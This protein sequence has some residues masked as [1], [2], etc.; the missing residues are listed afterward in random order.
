M[1]ESNRSRRKG[2]PPPPILDGPKALLSR[3]L[4]FLNDI[5]FPPHDS[6][7]AAKDICRKLHPASASWDPSLLSYVMGLTRLMEVWH[8]DGDFTTS[9]GDPRRLPLSGP[10]SFAELVARVLPDRSAR[11]VLHT[12]IRNRAVRRHGREVEGLGRNIRFREPKLV[13][14]HAFLVM[15]STVGVF[16]HN[17]HSPRPVPEFAATNA[18]IP[19]R[20]LPALYREMRPIAR[21]HA[22]TVDNLLG[23]YRPDTGS[24]EPITEA[25]YI[26]IVTDAHTTSPK[27]SASKSTPRNRAGRTPKKLRGGV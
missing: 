16:C 18:R 25:M 6:L 20:K 2:T 13:R 15:N 14:A 9:H 26:I 24:S 10:K 12:L 22:I 21:A 11:T 19:V 23:T 4:H 5:G 3:V 7:P 8:S 27:A 17:L 1:N